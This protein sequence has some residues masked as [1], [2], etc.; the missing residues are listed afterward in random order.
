MS[1]T[2]IVNGIEYHWWPKPTMNH[3]KR[4][5]YVWWI[6]NGRK[7]S[8]STKKRLKH[9]AQDVVKSWSS[10]PG[11]K[12]TFAECTKGFFDPDGPFLSWKP[13]SSVNTVYQHKYNLERILVNWYGKANPRNITAPDLEKR[14]R[15]YRKS[16]GDPLSSSSKN[17]VINTA[18]I[19]LSDL[20]RAHIIDELP[21]FHRPEDDSERKDPLLAADIEKLWPKDRDKII[22]VWGGDPYAPMFALM[23]LLGLHSG[24]RPSEIRAFHGD[25]IFPD[26]GC[27]LIS[28]MVTTSEEL[29]PVLK[30][31]SSDNPGARW[32]V[33]PESTMKALVAWAGDEKGPLF[34]YRDKFVKRDY[35]QRRFALAVQTAEIDT[36]KRWITTYSLRYTYRSRV[37]GWMP[38]TTIRD[39][40]GHRSEEM[41]RLYLH[42]IPEQVKA[43]QV[44]RPNVENIWKAS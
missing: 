32:A 4:I 11:R 1:G 19:V 12:T 18:R 33:V 30:K 16:N 36:T 24:M 22:Q 8:R 43:L 14:L 37:E 34:L 7:I 25:Q 31:R 41:S 44:Q 15:D 42:A 21:E 6:E 39:T 9:E 3:P 38:D 28:R 13:K 23:A 27:I 2:L 29:S 40:M 35:F 5:W 26:Y 17:S 10:A 20:K